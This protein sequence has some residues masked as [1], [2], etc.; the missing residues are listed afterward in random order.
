MIG[1]QS[2]FRIF[3][4]SNQADEHQ[5]LDQ[6]ADSA[7]P[8]CMDEFFERPLVKT[9]MLYA[10]ERLEG[11]L[12]GFRGE[13]AATEAQSEDVACIQLLHNPLEE[14]IGDVVKYRCHCTETRYHS[15][16]A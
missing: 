4:V 6:I 2:L 7:W 14:L 15:L 12:R 8:S 10:K 1:R 11:P 13:E 9:Y 16:G 5:I 3:Q